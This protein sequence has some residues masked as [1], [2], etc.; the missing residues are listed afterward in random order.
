MKEGKV[1]ESLI[2]NSVRRILTANSGLF[3]KPYPEAANIKKRVHLPAHIELAQ[4]VAEES[5]ILLQ[6][7]NK[8]LPLEI[9][10]LKNIAVVGPNA[11]QVQYGD[12]SLYA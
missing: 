9:G 3:E 1:S 6:N 12:Y 8:T 5:I 10:R 2:D 7:E 11:D 4:K